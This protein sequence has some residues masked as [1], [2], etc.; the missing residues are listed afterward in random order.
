MPK[1]VLEPI[2]P[3]I[4]VLPFHHCYRSQ[5]SHNHGAS[6]AQKN[7]GV[8]FRQ[9]RSKAA[10]SGTA[11][12][13]FYLKLPRYGRVS[14][15][16][17]GQ[18]SLEHDNLAG[19]RAL[20]ETKSVLLHEMGQTPTVGGKPS[21][22]ERDSKLPCKKNAIV[23]MCDELTKLTTAWTPL[24]CLAPSPTACWKMFYDASKNP[25]TRSVG[26]LASTQQHLF[27]FSARE[28]NPGITAW[29]HWLVL[30]TTFFFF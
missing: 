16:V 14:R 29:A 21:V 5:H 8:D 13:T 6:L 17:F 23:K 11:C 19:T 4:N 12:D 9:G 24:P 26:S 2:L 28:H 22:S 18:S 27:L 25:T 3:L 10:Q 1:L 15:S 7:C 30:S 20:F